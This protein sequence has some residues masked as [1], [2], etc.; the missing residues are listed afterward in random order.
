MMTINAVL[1]IPGIFGTFRS[2]SEI[3]SNTKLDPLHRKSSSVKILCLLVDIFAL[4]CQ[5]VGLI[6]WPVLNTSWTDN[7]EQGEL[8]KIKDIFMEIIY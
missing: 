5:I 2:I 4:I 1:L 7:V 8:I 3:K 6:L